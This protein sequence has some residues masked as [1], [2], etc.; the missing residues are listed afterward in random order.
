[1]IEVVLH[2]RLSESGIVCNGYLNGVPYRTART[3]AASF[4]YY[5]RW[6][7]DPD[8]R[9]EYLG[10]KEAGIQVNIPFASTGRDV[11]LFQVAKTRDGIPSD[12]LI[13]EARQMVLRLTDAVVVTYLGDTVTYGGDDITY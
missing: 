13:A 12:P 11:R 6:D 9:P 8:M 10:T 3:P 5:W 2:R 7:D 1:M 4:D